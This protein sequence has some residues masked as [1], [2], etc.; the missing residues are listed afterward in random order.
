VLAPGDQE[1]CRD[2]GYRGGY[3][4]HYEP[5][6]AVR[7]ALQEDGLEIKRYIKEDCVDNDGSQEVAEDDVRSGALSD[8]TQGH[9][10]Q[11][12]S[13]FNEDEKWK[14]NGEYNERLLELI[15]LEKWTSFGM[16]Y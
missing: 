15:S 7:C 9:Y 13:G 2:A 12:D 4:W 8:D 16:A 11:F 6:A 3:G 5:Q 10:G 14:S 1:A